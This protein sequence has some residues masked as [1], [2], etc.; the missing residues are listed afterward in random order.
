VDRARG[1]GIAGHTVD[2]TDLIACV[3]TMDRVVKAARAGGGSQLVIGSTLRLTGHGEHD[4]AS[5]IPAALKR[6]EIG[7]D[8]MKVAEAQLLEREWASESEIADWRQRCREEVEK[9]VTLAMKDAGPDPFKENWRALS[10]EH[11]SEGQWTA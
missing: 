5:Y 7:R 4:D 8:C 3:E 6:S 11:L 1:Y 9:T 2:G 10:T